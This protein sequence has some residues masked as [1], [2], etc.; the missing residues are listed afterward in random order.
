MRDKSL[1]YIFHDTID[2]T[3]EHK[4]TEVFE[5]TTKAIDEVLA[6]IKKTL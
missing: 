4:E 5:A 6:L 1:V 2:N 3:G